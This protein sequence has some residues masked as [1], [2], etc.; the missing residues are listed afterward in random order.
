MALIDTADRDRGE[1]GRGGRGNGAGRGGHG[2]HGEQER[3][4]REGGG[5]ANEG[6][7]FTNVNNN[8][9][10]GCWNCDSDEHWKYQCPKLTE[11]ERA[12][13][14]C[15]GG[16]EGPSLLTI[17]DAKDGIYGAEDEYNVVA[18]VLPVMV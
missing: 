4:K 9:Q 15:K 16:H 2:E 10:K 1:P 6:R 14:R 11:E 3:R 12:E 7:D 5:Y 17:A 13:L 18:F 8:R